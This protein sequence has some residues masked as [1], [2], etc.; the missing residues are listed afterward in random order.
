MRDALIV[1][2]LTEDNLPSY[3]HKIATRF[4]REEPGV[5]GC[6]AGTRRRTGT[7][8]PCART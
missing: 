2:P 7:H 4:G 5:P 8:T 1:N 6:T 3:H